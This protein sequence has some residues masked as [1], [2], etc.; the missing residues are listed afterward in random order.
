MNP[1]ARILSIGTALPQYS[2]HQSDTVQ[3]AQAIGLSQRWW[4]ALPK[5]YSK[6]GVQTRHSVLL[7]SETGSPVDRQSFYLSG[8]GESSRGPTTAQRLRK[9]EEHAGALLI[10]SSRRAAEK[11]GLTLDRVTHLVTVSCTGFSAPGV[12]HHLI[13]G[14]PLSNRVQRT[15][16]GFMGCHG[17]INGVRVAQSIAES[18]PKAVV[19]V[20]AV[21]LCSLH[22]QHSDHPQ[23]LVANALFSDGAASVL[24][25]S[26]SVASATPGLTW[27]IVANLSYRIPGTSEMMSWRVG[28]YGFEMTLSPEVPSVIES[29]L[30]ALFSDWLQSSG[31]V[32]REAIQWAVHPGGPRILDSVVSALSLDPSHVQKSRDVLSSHGNM[33]SPT[34]LFILD[35]IDEPSVRTTCILLGFGPGLSVEAVLLRSQSGLRDEN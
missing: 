4:H 25:T 2:I 28:D 10:E 13:D 35:Q 9:F 29:A 12:D 30:P 19:L 32:D 31:V 7:N 20:G 11:A 26:D 8:G 6:T 33:S 34:L 16:V 21:E 18:D 3:I 23:Q 17:A 24:V 22:Q 15:N 14:L 27:D 1:T 5:L